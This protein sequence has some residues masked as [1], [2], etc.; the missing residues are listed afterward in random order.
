MAAVKTRAVRDGD[1]WVVN[2]EKTWITNGEYSDILICTCRTG[3]N[4]DQPYPD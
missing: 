3:E 1:H 2:G 4:E